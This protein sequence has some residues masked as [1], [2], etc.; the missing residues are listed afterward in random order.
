MSVAARLTGKRIC[1]CTGA[2]GVGKTTTAAAVAIG[3]AARGQRVAVVTIDPA[4][5]L[6]SSLGLE[7][8]DNEPRR[9]EPAH[10]AR[11]GLEFRGELWAMMLDAKRTFDELIELLAPNSATY[12]SIL[13]NR[14]YQELSSSVA[15]SQE[16]SAVAKL[17]ELDASG[18]FDAIVLDT[19]PSRNALDFLDAP[20]RLTGFL[21]GRALK[22]LT[23]PTGV[24][25]AI[26]ARGSS[27]VFSILR[28]V[29][30]VDL[31]AD[32]G[33][34]FRVLSEVVDG[35][36]ERAS[37]VARLLGDPATTFLIVT[38]PEPTPVQE[39]VFFRRR[40]AEAG[41]HFG[42]L[43]VNRQRVLART[44]PAIDERA[45]AADLGGD[46]DLAARS[47]R[48]LRDLRALAR[49]DAGNLKYLTAEL[50]DRHPIVIPQMHHD[51]S[52]LAGLL[53]IERY[54][55]AT[56]RERSALLAEQAF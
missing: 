20:R 11:H 54:L 41:M 2:G 4:R 51:I 53:L 22:V 9:V 38:S 26:A 46:S 35:F 52:D 33:E 55:F 19:P 24:V 13:S 5:R 10:F 39:A 6:A 28:R 16:F 29:T 7:E 36:A 37:V 32:L 40:L 12:D 44:R 31:L 50:D 48:A 18:R 15:G 14:I 42:G 30:G 45:L 56:T 47:V 1:I 25:A 34:F 43:I 3:L 21:E 8:L 23:A 17:Y 49:R 27:L